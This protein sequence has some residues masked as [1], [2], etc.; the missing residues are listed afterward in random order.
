M[1]SDPK[2]SRRVHTPIARPLTLRNGG[3][4][5]A[6]S[7]DAGGSEGSSEGG[8]ASCGGVFITGKSLGVGVLPALDTDG[9]RAGRPGLSAFCQCRSAHL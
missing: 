2:I 5:R 3:R 1:N 9:V 6:T 7:V 8:M 4:N